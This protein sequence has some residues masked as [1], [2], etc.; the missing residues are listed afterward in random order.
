MVVDLADDG[1][2]PF[3]DDHATRLVPDGLVIHEQVEAVLLVLGVENTGLQVL[4]I[5]LHL[6]VGENGESD[7][8]LDSA[9]VFAVLEPYVDRG[10]SRVDHGVLGCRIARDQRHEPGVLGVRAG[11]EDRRADFPVVSEAGHAPGAD[12]EV[13]DR[14]GE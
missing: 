8:G 10:E 3:G 1:E 6:V 13:L 5:E 2:P 11:F 14:P 4:G 12:A 7:A 9:G